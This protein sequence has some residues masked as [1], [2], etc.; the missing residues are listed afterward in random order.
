M[1]TDQKATLDGLAGRLD[2]EYFELQE[3]AEDGKATADDYM[4]PFGQARAVSALSFAANRDAFEAATE[5]IYEAA[6]AT[7]DKDELIADVMKT[8]E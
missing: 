3:A 5:A 1:S 4:R 6:T 7:D 2:D 8:L